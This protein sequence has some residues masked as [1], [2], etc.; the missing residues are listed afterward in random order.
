MY[1]INLFVPGLTFY[2]SINDVAIFAKGT[3]YIPNSILPEKSADAKTIEYLLESVKRSNMNII[4]IWGGGIYESDY[5]YEVTKFS[6][7]I[8]SY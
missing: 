4:R 6:L 7:N 8:I 5:F 1:R 2:F 3:N